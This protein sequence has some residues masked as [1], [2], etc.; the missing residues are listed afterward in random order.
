MSAAIFIFS[1]SFTT[2]LIWV[3]I[4]SAI[5]AYRRRKIA[6][7]LLSASTLLMVVS[8]AIPLVNLLI[9]G[10]GEQM[11]IWLGVQFVAFVLA[12]IGLA[13]FNF[14]LGGL[15]RLQTQG[16]SLKQI[17]LLRN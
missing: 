14:P 13:T 12:L 11:E 1:I 10:F 16:I 3:C 9:G 4:T 6:L 8:Q 5:A 17:L 15:A 7:V 2:I